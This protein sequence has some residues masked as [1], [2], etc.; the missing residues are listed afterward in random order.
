LAH[1]SHA[2]R[3]DAC[4]PTFALQ[5][6]R[7]DPFSILDAFEEAAIDRGRPECGRATKKKRERDEGFHLELCRWLTL[8]VITGSTLT[9][10]EI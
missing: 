5:Q 2:P 8:R 4:D 10:A 3:H 7:G 1:R 6:I 9:S